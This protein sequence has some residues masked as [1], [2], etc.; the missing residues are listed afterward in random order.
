MDA[1]ELVG[2]YVNDEVGAY[3]GFKI[4]E[5][6]KIVLLLDS[7]YEEVP[8]AKICKTPNGYIV[9]AGDSTGIAYVEKS[10]D[11]LLVDAFEIDEKVLNDN[12][13]TLNIIGNYQPQNTL[14]LYCYN[15]HLNHNYYSFFH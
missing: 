5:D 6:G 9:N 1:L 8:E 12:N 14:I 10:G 4:N 3:G 7:E 2:N 15:N 11:D 13:I